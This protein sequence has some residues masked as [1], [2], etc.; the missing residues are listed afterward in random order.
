MR[1]RITRF[2]AGAIATFRFSYD[3]TVGDL[4]FKLKSRVSFVF[5]RSN[6]NWSLVHEHW[7]SCE[8]RS[9]VLTLIER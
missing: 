5:E 9:E 3:M 6:G 1:L 8:L 2:L 7:S 4:R